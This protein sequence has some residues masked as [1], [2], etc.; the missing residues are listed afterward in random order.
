VTGERDVLAAAA[1]ATAAP[2]ASAAT[3]TS[4]A[5]KKSPATAAVGTN[6]ALD[7]TTEA[8]AAAAAAVSSKV[9]GGGAETRG[10]RR[11]MHAISENSA[12]GTALLEALEDAVSRGSLR[13]RVATIADSPLVLA[14][15]ADA[16][17]PVAF[18]EPTVDVRVR[19]C[20]AMEDAKSSEDGRD[21]PSS[22]AARRV[23]AEELAAAAATIPAASAELK[24]LKRPAGGFVTADRTRDTWLVVFCLNE[25]PAVERGRTDDRPTSVGE[26]VASVASVADDTDKECRRRISVIKRCRRWV[27]KRLCAVGRR[28]SCCCRSAD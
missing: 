17:G 5:T 25:S 19:V 21:V 27:A 6:V 13:G 15:A 23:S 26:D 14:E 12:N 22:W 3:E 10:D 18:D 28:V 16:S 8:V 11:G 9:T 24:A 1:A 7:R 20:G 2:E 4:A